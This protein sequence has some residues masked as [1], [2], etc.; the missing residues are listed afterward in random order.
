MTKSLKVSIAVLVVLVLIFLFL[1]VLFI[2]KN[3]SFLNFNISRQ[4]VDANNQNS[5]VESDTSNVLFAQQIV[6]PDSNKVGVFAAPQTLNL[7]QAFTISVWAAGLNAPRQIDFTNENNIV[8]AERGA[9]SIK[10]I[11]QSQDGTLGLETITI[12]SSLDNVHSVDYYSGD[13]Y[14][15]EESRIVVYR[16]LTEDGTYTNKEVLID[17]LPQ[18]GHWSRTVKVG[19]DNKLYITVGSSCNLCEEADGRRAAM[20]TANLDGSNLQPYAT[21]LRNTVDFVFKSTPVDFKI[22]GVDNGRDL[23]G[24]DL[25]PDEVNIISQGLNYGWPYCYGQGINN[26]EY[27]ERSGY[28]KT[29]TEIPAFNLQAH[30]AALG[31]T[32]LVNDDLTQKVKFPQQIFKDDLFI[33][34]HGSWNRTIPTGYKVVRVNTSKPAGKEINFITG[35]LNDQGQVWGR[36]VDVK[37]DKNGDLYITDDYAGAIYKVQYSPL[38]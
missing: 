32:F 18:G 34:F 11:K 30:S 10:F 36:P 21:G 22:W 15:G 23:I 20:L 12:D 28:C 17:N 1:A 13:L 26:P 9:D 2:T 24:D 4:E 37:F 7:P 8:V 6:V 31:L 3:T 16:D 35:W 14:V 27:P 29:E 38:R 33:A 25:P 19:P 5:Q